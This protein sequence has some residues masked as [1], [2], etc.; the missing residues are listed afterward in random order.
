MLISRLVGLR[1]DLIIIPV[2]VHVVYNTQD[3]YVSRDQ[4]NSQIDALNRD[5][6]KMNTD[7]IQ[8][9][10]RLCS[11]FAALAADT[12]I[13]FQ[14]AKR[15]PDCD[16]IPEG[17]ITWTKTTMS[18]FSPPDMDAL[19]TDPTLDKVKHSSVAPDGTQNGGHDA[20]PTDKYLNIWVCNIDDG[21]WAGYTTFPGWPREV[22]GVVIHYDYFGTLNK[23]PPFDK[24]RTTTHE[25]GHWLNLH[26]PWGDDVNYNCLNTDF[27]LDTPNQKDYNFLCPHSIPNTNTEYYYQ[28]CTAS[29]DPNKRCLG[30]PH[31]SCK[32]ASPNGDMFINY[33]DYAQDR[34]MAMFTAG[35]ARRMEALLNGYRRSIRDSQ[36]YVPPTPNG[37]ADLWIRDSPRDLGSEPDTAAGPMFASDDIFVNPP[38]GPFIVE[39]GNLIPGET[40][41]IYVN[42]RNRGC[43]QSSGGKVI[44]YWAKASTGLGWPAPWDGSVTAPAPMGGKIGEMAIGSVGP[45]SMKPLRFD[46]VPPDPADYAAFGADRTHFCLLARIETIR[47]APYGM[48]SPEGPNLWENVRNNN[49]IAWK[50]VTIAERLVWGWRGQL[51][52]NS[53]LKYRKPDPEHMPVPEQKPERGLAPIRLTFQSAVKY[54]LESPYPLPRSVLDLGDVELD[55]GPSLFSRWQA[56]GMPGRGVEAAGGSR[57]AIKE[58]QAR[59][60]VKIPHDELYVVEFSVRPGTPKIKG[61]DAFFFDI[62]QEERVKRSYR[63]VGGQRFIIQTL[64]DGKFIG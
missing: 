4:V 55:L 25:V 56:D 18:K 57:V 64:N 12:R 7:G 59:I 40:N 30:F 49:N 34:C 32:N 61:Y 20:W 26:H 41:H 11:D 19:K 37:A 42:I 48:T 17:A 43:R 28:T 63:H 53:I 44:L 50:N 10:E 1:P 24:G 8:F 54:P 51:L 52:V 6:Q 58:P 29:S 22:D 21:D 60:E 9:A 3:Q 23:A 5:Y 33:M 45:S 15:G 27:V 35:Q 16:Y 38:S 62:V 13:E 36:G 2:V 47:H 31:I 46:W 14:L 39:S